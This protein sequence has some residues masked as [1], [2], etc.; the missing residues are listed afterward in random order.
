M[1]NTVHMTYDLE[2]PLTAM[3]QKDCRKPVPV[4]IEATSLM[5]D[6]TSLR[7]MRR[8]NRLRRLH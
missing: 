6:T 1:T 5:G 4:N 2:A 8:R 7:R 3:G